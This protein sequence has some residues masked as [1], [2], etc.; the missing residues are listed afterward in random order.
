MGE[1]GA[2]NSSAG[3]LFQES[4]ATKKNWETYGPEESIP[5][6]NGVGNGEGNAPRGREV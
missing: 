2:D 4:C 5:D 3:N 6:R 1:N